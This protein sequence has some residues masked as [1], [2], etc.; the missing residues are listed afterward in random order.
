MGMWIV[1]LPASSVANHLK[2]SEGLLLIGIGVLGTLGQIF[3]TQGYKYTTVSTGSILGMLTPVIN[4]SAGF[5]LFDEP[6]TIHTLIGSL[7]VIVS[8]IFVIASN[9]KNEEII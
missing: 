7:V 5:M 9:E 4:F 6:Y 2:Y 1:L 3:M 8:C